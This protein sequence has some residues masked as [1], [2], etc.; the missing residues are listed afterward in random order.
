MGRPRAFDMDQ[1]STC[2][3]RGYDGASVADLTEA[4]GINP[5][6]PP[7]EMRRSAGGTLD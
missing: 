1:R 5:P 2:S 7:R 6:A 3:G 4:I